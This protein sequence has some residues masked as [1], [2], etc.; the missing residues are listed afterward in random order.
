MLLRLVCLL[1]LV[2]LPACTDWYVREGITLKE[3]IAAEHPKSMRLTRADGS[4]MVVKQPRVVG[5]DSLAGFQDGVYSNL[6]F[7]D[8]TQVATQKVSE[9]RTIALAVAIASLSAV[10][11]DLLPCDVKQNCPIDDLSAHHVGGPN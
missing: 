8:V 11:Y 1:L 9:S 6:A 5:S 2:S 7:A 3:L 10:T 4:R